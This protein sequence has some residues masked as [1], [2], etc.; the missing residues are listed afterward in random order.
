MKYKEGKYTL[1]EYD[2]K[3]LRELSD[4]ARIT[5]TKLGEKVGKDRVTTC[6]RIKAME[7]AGI[8]TGYTVIIDWDMVSA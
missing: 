4:N 1:D 5:M 2:N 8:I 6:Q 3:I 7:E